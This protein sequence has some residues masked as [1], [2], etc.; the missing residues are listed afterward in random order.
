MTSVLIWDPDPLSAAYLVHIYSE[1]GLRPRRFT[2]YRTFQQAQ[3]EH[4]TESC[5]VVFALGSDA[6]KNLAQI[7]RLRK[8]LPLASIII[9]SHHQ[10][11]AVCLS[12]FAAGADDYL[13]KP[14]AHQE[15]LARSLAHVKRSAEILAA[16]LLTQHS[17]T[18]TLGPLNLNAIQREALIE[19]QSL[20][21]SE[22]EFKLLHLLVSHQGQYLSRA[23]LSRRLWQGNTP[24]RKID[25]LVLALRKKL[26]SSLLIE[27]RYGQGYTIRVS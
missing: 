11:Q 24:P 19:G 1:A 25:N 22:S 26:P 27:S 2:G 6:L 13:I 5:L 16:Y 8:N 20:R 3:A 4:R 9:L 10:E 21:L 12:A 17:V 15:L 14:F 7:Q 18:L 23:Q